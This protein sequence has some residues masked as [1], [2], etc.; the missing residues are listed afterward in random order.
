MKST[1]QFFQ[2]NTDSFD[3]F[4]GIFEM[5]DVNFQTPEDAGGGSM[6]PDM[7]TPNFKHKKAQ[8]GTYSAR[9]RF[10]PNVNDKTMSKY[11]KYM[12]FLT[13]PE[14]NKFYVDCTSN[15]GQKNNIITA[16]FFFLKDSEDVLLKGMSR[17][18]SRKQYWFSL[19]QI[20]KD[21][22]EEELQG[23]V[24]IFRFAQQ[25]NKVIENLDKGDP[26][27]GQ[28]PV[29]VF[30]I[31]KGRD[32]FLKVN[33]KQYDDKGT[34]RKMTSYE[35]GSFDGMSTAISLDGGNTRMTF[36]GNPETDRAS[37]QTIFN[38]LKEKSPSLDKVKAK[39][40]DDDM[41]IRITDSI[42]ASLNDDNLFNQIYKKSQH[43]GGGKSYNANAG[44]TE[45]TV[46]NTVAS[47]SLDSAAPVQQAA[48]A[49]Q[50]LNQAAEIN[51][52]AANISAQP[53][54]AAAPAQQA[55]PAPA[56][57]PAQQAAPA[58]QPGFETFGKGINF[59]EL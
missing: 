29:K 36:T 54:P 42:R 28:L 14:G 34:Q 16:A 21:I 52:L 39:Q 12:Y 27:T 17:Q 3:N 25:I 57:A 33:E 18:F 55:A 19:V 47:Q 5:D 10:V 50:P 38:Y 15:W 58:A 32:Y 40:W 31:T 23:T 4:G 13:D 35:D 1:F 51:N 56:A 45:G 9:L 59:D 53:T 48:P 20:M 46:S 2:R 26:S 37:M 7:Y 6:D 30:D 43:K 49:A 24:K 11:M 44:K 8:G 41:T 22:Q